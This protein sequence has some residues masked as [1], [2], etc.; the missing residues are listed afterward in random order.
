MH[1]LGIAQC[2]IDIALR[3]ARDN[4]GGKISTVRIQ[5]GELR[6]IIA[7]QLQFCFAFAAK[8]TPAEG[9][10][11][12]VDVLPIEAVCQDCRK[13]F[14]VKNFEFRCPDCRATSVR[15]V[16]GQELRIKEV[17]LQ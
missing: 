15:V 17:E 14:R 11:L 6:S 1:E 3:A 7:D 8:D 9:A 2:I 10:K 4:G 5:A 12:E 16:R 13:E